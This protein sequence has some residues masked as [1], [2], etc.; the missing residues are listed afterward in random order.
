MNFAQVQQV[1]NDLPATF[2]RQ[3]APF[4]QL[5]DSLTD[6]EALYT[7]AADGILAQTGFAI[8]GAGWLD[9]WGLL[10]GVPRESNEADSFYRSRIV[11]TVTSGNGTA[12][13][14]QL[15]ILIVWRVQVTVTEN[16]PNLG[17]TVTFPATVTQAQIQQIMAALGRIR[18]AGVPITGVFAL[19]GAAVL[20]TVNFLSAPRVTGAF[21][22]SNSESAPLGVSIPAATNNAQPLIPD[23]YLTDPTLNPS[24][25]A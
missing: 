2:L 21:M 4:T 7:Q 25:A 3:G 22:S 5:T 11:F 15:W 16:L 20:Q 1:L 23:L 12:L 8:A 24:L 13:G 14:I 10:F 19:S 9:L 6:G 18:P 17:Y